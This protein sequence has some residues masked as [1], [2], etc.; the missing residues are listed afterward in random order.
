[1][2]AAVVEAPDFHH[3]CCDANRKCDDRYV[4][5]SVDPCLYQSSFHQCHADHNLL[6]NQFIQTNSAMFI[7]HHSWAEQAKSL[8]GISV[9]PTARGIAV[10]TVKRRQHQREIGTNG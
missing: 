4:N 10:A 9:G 2:G 1:M 3:R 8:L 5:L 7:E 6:N